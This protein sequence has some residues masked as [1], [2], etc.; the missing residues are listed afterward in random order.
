MKNYKGSCHCGKVQF[1]AQGDITNAISCNCSICHRKGTV[2]SFVP[3]AQFKLISGSDALTDYQFGKK[4]IHHTFCSTCG[5]QPFGSGSA[6]DG[7]KMMALNV[8][9][10]DGIN[11]KDLTINEYDGKAI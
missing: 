6:P 11:L 1:E 7:T 3:E 2:L 8:R 4:K 10:M 5:V 9:C